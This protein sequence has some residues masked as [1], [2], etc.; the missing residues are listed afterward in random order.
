MP[1]DMATKINLK[2]VKMLGDDELEKQNLAFMDEEQKAKMNAKAAKLVGTNVV[3]KKKLRDRFGSEMHIES[4][5]MQK[6]KEKYEKLK[7][8]SLA[9]WVAGTV[10]EMLSAK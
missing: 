9:G 2:A 5:E 3:L 10:G 4:I 1:A 6:A 7:A 8:D